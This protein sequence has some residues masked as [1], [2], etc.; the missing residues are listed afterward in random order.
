MWPAAA[1]N[2]NILRS[3]ER[4]SCQ[5]PILSALMN[6]CRI[7]IISKYCNHSFALGLVERIFFLF[8]MAC[9]ISR[10]TSEPWRWPGVTG[11][12]YKSLSITNADRSGW[13][14]CLSTSS[15]LG[16]LYSAGLMSLSGVPSPRSSLL[17]G[18]VMSMLFPEVPSTGSSLVIGCGTSKL[19]SHVPSSGSSLLMRGYGTL[20]VWQTSIAF[21]TPVTNKCPRTTLVIAFPL[22]H[23]QQ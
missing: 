15:P 5:L 21:K 4:C 10:R 23:G 2:G 8:S 18:Y 19:L 13:G 11:L 3:D 6:C 9:L 20:N 7:W 12:S 1:R 22:S 14:N 16:G 17:M